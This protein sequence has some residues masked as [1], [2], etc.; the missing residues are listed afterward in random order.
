MSYKNF[1]PEIWAETI[2]RNLEK[3][4]VFVADCN[5]EYEGKVSKMGD[6]VHILGTGTP[7]ITT[8]IG[9][10]IELKGAETVEG[11]EQ[12]MVIDHVSYFDYMIDDI[13]KRQAVGGVMDALS[14]ETSQ[15]LADEQD[16]A[17]AN[18]CADKSLFTQEVTL[19]VD[20]ILGDIDTAMVKLFE[21]NVSTGMGLS[22]TIPPVMWKVIKQ[23]YV[24]ADMN[25]SEML[26]NGKVGQYGS[27]DI[28]MSNNVYKDKSGYFYVP[29]KTNKAFAFANPLTHNEPYRPESR[30]S[31][32]VKGYVLYGAKVVRPKE[33]VILKFKA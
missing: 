8:Q 19:S 30:F 28:K 16:K 27:V 26:K 31:D 25:N 9:G 29:I 4:H 7:T 32:A 11:N 18:L 2:Q 14:A 12:T 21:N 1:I 17:V 13:D 10:D 3:D 22:M 24:K 20:N 6:T 23:A 5:R 15:A 33:C